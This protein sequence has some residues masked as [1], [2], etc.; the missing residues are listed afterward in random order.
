MPQP[1]VPDGPPEETA[2]GN[3]A[4]FKARRLL[5]EILPET[6]LREFLTRGFFHYEGKGVVY[7]ICEESQTEMYGNGRLLATAC[8]RLSVPAPGCDRMIAEYLILKNNEAF[9]WNTANVFPAKPKSFDSR[10]F[11]MALLNLA[12]FLKLVLSYLT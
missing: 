11:L 3:S 12:L 8:L 7:R 2:D 9:Y 10:L 6:A 5:C 1:R 4:R